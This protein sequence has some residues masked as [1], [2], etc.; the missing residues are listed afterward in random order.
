M[1]DLE[2]IKQGLLFRSLTDDEARLFA[3][4]A[5]KSEIESGKV[6]I[7]EGAEGNA[8]YIVEEGQVAVTKSE[9]DVR[10]TIVT[11][12]RGEHFGEMSILES[13]PTSARVSADG[14]VTLLKIPRS[15]FIEI[16]EKNDKVAA[17]VYKSIA[18]ALSHRLRHT[19][20]DLVTWKP[21]FEF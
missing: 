13:A 12:E 7:E 19:S 20:A 9:G 8:I 6:I 14:A 17:K 2:L 1:A 18:L 16:I 4:I 10:S 15:K 5:E 21:G 11:L 3:D